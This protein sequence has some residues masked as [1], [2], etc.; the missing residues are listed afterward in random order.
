MLTLVAVDLVCQYH[1]QPVST[2]NC[3]HK[4][5][6]RRRFKRSYYVDVVACLFV[7]ILSS[8]HC[9]IPIIQPLSVTTHMFLNAMVN[10]YHCK[11]PLG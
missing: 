8:L 7:V 3:I 1:S 4:T 5:R 6:L 9:E 11:L 2:K 10:E